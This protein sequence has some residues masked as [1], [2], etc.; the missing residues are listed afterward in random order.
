[1]RTKK[2]RT[3]FWVMMVTLTVSVNA[4]AAGYNLQGYTFAI[5]GGILSTIWI[6]RGES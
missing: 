1:M 3:L 6:A 4:F 5:F 2:D